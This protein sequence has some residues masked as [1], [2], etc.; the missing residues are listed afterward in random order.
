MPRRYY[1]G[2]RQLW[3]FSLAMKNCAAPRVAEPQGWR[4]G[5]RDNRPRRTGGRLKN[6]DHPCR[7]RMSVISIV[8]IPEA[9]RTDYSYAGTASGPQNPAAGR[10][11][12]A[13]ER[14]RLAP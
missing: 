3:C 8:R 4:M 13:V 11:I 7:Y 5:K 1:V 9:T 6:G 14:G 2:A 10:G 12:L